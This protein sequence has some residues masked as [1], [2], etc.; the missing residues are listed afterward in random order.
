MHDL[1]HFIRSNCEEKLTLRTLADQAHLS[2]YH[3]QRKFKSVM[4]LTPKEYLDACR[5]QKLRAGL[6][7]QQTVTEAMYEA[8]FSSSSRLYENLDTRLGMTPKQFQSRGERVEISYAST[9]TSF[10]LVLMAATDR[11]ICFIQFGSSEKSLSE[12]L[13]AEFPRAVI[14]KMP[15]KHRKQFAGWAKVLNEYLEGHIKNIK[16]PL[17]IRGT[18]FQVIVWK[19]LQKIPYGEIVSYSDVAQAIGKPKAVRAVATACARNNIAIVIPCHRV[20]RGNGELAGYRWG[21][22]RK[23]QLLKLEKKRK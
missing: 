9:R 14:S 17:D 18:V 22:E 10:G 21:I 23:R 19:Y 3:L 4:G 12:Q 7:R 8:G 20:L 6:K 2:I 11:G 13:K 15:Q 1:A 16:L 5:L